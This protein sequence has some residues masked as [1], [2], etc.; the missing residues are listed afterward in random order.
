MKPETRLIDMDLSVRAKNCLLAAE[1]YTLRELLN[2]DMNSFKKFRNVG[3]KTIRELR[4]FIEE[5]TP[6][7]VVEFEQTKSNNL[8]IENLDLAFRMCKIQI[9]KGLID[10]IID[11]V[12][13]VQLRGNQTTIEDITNLQEHWKFTNN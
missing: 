10:N 8:T 12:E 4:E 3:E 1:I 9:H 5:Y 6:K 13:L 2:I 7:F 11:V